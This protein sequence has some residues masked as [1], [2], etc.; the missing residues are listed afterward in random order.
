MAQ[1]VV[2]S[3]RKRCT[4]VTLNEQDYNYEE[5]RSIRGNVI[6]SGISKF[7]KKYKQTQSLEN[8][9]DK[10]RK[11]C[12]TASDVRRIKRMGLADRKKIISVH[13]DS[14]QGEVVQF[15]V[16]VKRARTVW[17]RLHE[18]SIKAR[19]PRKSHFCL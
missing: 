6:K 3:H 5:I 4:K 13:G 10:G 19:I 18:F 14:H 1:K 9:T 17:C 11:R 12:T 15:N 16:N 8:Q 2:C 7:L